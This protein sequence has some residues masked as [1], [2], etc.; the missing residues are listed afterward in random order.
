MG[1]QLPSRDFCRRPGAARRWSDHSP[2][3]RQPLVQAQGDSVLTPQRPPRCRRP[4]LKECHWPSVL[5]YLPSSRRTRGN[6]TRVA[7]PLRLTPAYLL[8]W[9]RGGARADAMLGATLGLRRSTEESAYLQMRIRSPGSRG[10]P[11]QCSPASLEGE[12]PAPAPCRGSLAV[13]ASIGVAIT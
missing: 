8:P 9:S 7:S 5:P 2:C 12:A 10:G 11:L 1:C 6:D 13:A 3:S 4:A